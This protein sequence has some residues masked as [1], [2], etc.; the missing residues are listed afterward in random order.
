[1]AVLVT[2]I[3]RVLM[4]V[5]AMFVVLMLVSMIVLVIAFDLHAAGLVPKGDG[6]HQCHCQ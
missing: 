2:A 1:M 3:G 6:T 4:I 5:F